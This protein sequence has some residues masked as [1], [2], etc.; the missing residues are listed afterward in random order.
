MLISNM[1]IGSEYWLE[2]EQKKEQKK[3]A[4]KMD[5][6][7]AILFMSGRTAIDYAIETIIKKRKIET[8]YFPSYCCQSMLEPFLS[9]NIKILFYN[10]SFKDG[11]FIYDIDYNKKCD[12]FF[13]MNYFGFYSSNMDYY[14][15][16]FKEKD[17]II[18]EDSTHSCFSKRKYNYNSDFVIASLRKWLPIIS[19]G[20][21]INLSKR[22]ELD[23]NINLKKNYEY[24]NLKKNA[25]EEKYRYIE[26]GEKIN[27]EVFL[28]K[29]HKAEE[30]LNVEYK[31]YKID[32]ISYEILRNVNLDKIIKKRKDNVKVIYNFLKKQ[33]K[34]KYIK[35]IDF[36][37]D[38]LLFVPI[39]LRNVDRNRLKENLIKNDVYCPNHWPI[40]TEIYGSKEKEIYSMELSLICDQRYKTEDVIT[41]LKLISNII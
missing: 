1:E 13:A 21:L 10:V 24:I 25:M 23:K 19:G 36:E 6:K 14:I 26:N 32:N 20:I 18:I 3:E 11:H 22:F 28:E 16:K 38:C 4:N 15:N 33:S 41:Y 35:N 30:I 5:N 7:N 31:N 12:V 8:V 29:F 37:K 17:V 2:K 39:F 9:R 40:P 34:I 27:K